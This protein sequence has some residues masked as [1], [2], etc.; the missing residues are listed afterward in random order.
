MKGKVVVE[1]AELPAGKAALSNCEREPIHTPGT[2]QPFGVL[3]VA[4][5]IDLRLVY[6]SANAESL[7][8]IPVEKMLGKPLSAC[9]GQELTRQL[10]YCAD[11]EPLA[12]CHLV[13]PLSADP[14]AGSFHLHF[15]AHNDLVYVEIEPA[16]P[17]AGADEL[18]TRTQIIMNSLRSA[19]SLP[20]LLSEAARHLR[21]LTG[22]DRVMVYQFVRDGHGYVV[23]EDCAREMTPFLD[24][25]YPAS[26]IPSQ[27]KAVYLLQRIRV[28]PN[29]TYEPVPI[30]VA[31]TADAMVDP[32]LDASL[33]GLEPLDLTYCGLRSPSPTHLEFTR[34]MGAG[35]TMG[36][37]LVVNHQLW[38]LVICHHREPRL[39]SPAMRGCCDLLGQIVSSLIGQRIE[40]DTHAQA[41]EAQKSLM[42]ISAS[43]RS[44]SSVLQCLVENEQRVLSLVAAGGAIICF[45]GRQQCIGKTPPQQAAEQ[46]M[47][48]LRTVALDKVVVY[49]TAWEMVPDVADVRQ[50]ASGVLLM[51]TLME[52]FEGITWFRP[53]VTAT[54]RWG[55]DPERPAEID[56]ITGRLTPRKCFDVWETSFQGHS[57][58]WQDSDIDA[59]V[60]LKGII[61]K[62]RVSEAANALSVSR[63]VDPLTLL[64]NRRYFQEKLQGWT[65][66]KDLYAGAV[67]LIN[68]DRFKVVNEALGH[69][70]GDDLLIQVARRFSVLGS[71]DILI[72][73]LGG[74]EFAAF[75]QGLTTAQV[76]KA[77][78]Q[79]RKLLCAPFQ[80]FGKPFRLTASIG[81][82]HNSHGGEEE[83][84]WAA[85]VAMHYAKRSG[86]NRCMAFNKLLQHTAIKSMETEQDL[87]RALEAKEFTLVYQPLVTLPQGE[88]FGFEALLRWNHPSKGTIR[89]LDFIP[90]AEET[91]LIVPIGE[92]AL[93]EG[94]RRIKEWSVASGRKLILHVNVAAQQLVNPSFVPLLEKQIHEHGI[95]PESLSVEVTESILMRDVAVEALGRLRKLGV[96]V[97]IDDFG[98]GYSSL[99][100]LRKL[101]V[102]LVKIDQSF[103][104]PAVEDDKS[105]EFLATILKLTQTLGLKAIAE[106]VETDQ[107]RLALVKAGCTSA[108]GYLFSR[109]L[110]PE[111]IQKLI[112]RCK[113]AGDWS[114]LAS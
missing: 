16:G 42:E 1:V 76:D 103:V 79:V 92:W 90:L 85:D 61:S 58:P 67:I 104:R 34:N 66:R 83:L 41:R 96:G 99:A 109:P 22:Y 5:M 113:A 71:E 107:Q 106:G 64:P 40:C 68:L 44:G 31:S 86:R 60:S 33:A 15:R 54:L 35:A 98:T 69:A 95:E 80:V 2:I 12:M 36:L 17:Q 105:R 24:L 32:I 50:Q 62:F 59:A 28:V 49:D 26:D 114:I 70:S 37:S 110:K 94:A 46:L 55:G 89:P 63:M 39:P 23:A 3:L 45:D 43:L 10:L 75:C 52:P 73:R 100:Y 25:H 65:E 91:G 77:A 51:S 9:L 81:V 57:L 30:M 108:Q 13:A 11:G 29:T 6:A 93:K 19:E 56:S 7:I 74:D 27:A 102:D 111:D 47:A 112:E 20:L 48:A 4:R 8:G 84:L 101:P 82:A 78:D 53:E 72:A 97:S 21:S 18:S 38:G 88:L 14:L 87:Y